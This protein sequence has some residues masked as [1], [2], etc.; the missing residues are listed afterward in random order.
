MLDKDLLLLPH[1]IEH[2]NKV[3]ELASEC[4]LFLKRDNQAFPISR[5]CKVA[6]FGSG[7]RHTYKG[8][9]GS[10]DVNSHFFNTIE[11]E[12]ELQG[13]EITTKKWLDQY[14]I[15]RKRFHKEDQD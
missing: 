13:F 14:D 3:N 8:G 15:E 12:L 4:A 1:E 11:K 6:L 5:P 7:A 2:Y 10:G 9:T